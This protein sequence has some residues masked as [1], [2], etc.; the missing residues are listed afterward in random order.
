VTRR[1]S[2]ATWRDGRGAGKQTREDAEALS[3]EGKQTTVGRKMRNGPMRT[4]QDGGRDAESI[5]G[6]I[7]ARFLML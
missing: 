6:N 4:T 7:F 5:K 3:E 1:T 2:I